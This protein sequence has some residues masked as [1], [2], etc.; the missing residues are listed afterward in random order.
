MLSKKRKF[1]E[2][3]KKL[4]NNIYKK[5]FENFSDNSLDLKKISLRNC[6]SEKNGI[7]AGP[8]GSSIKKSDYVP[9]GFRVYGQEQVIAGRFDIG[10]YYISKSKYESLKSCS[11]KEDDI[12]IS[13]VGTFGK[14]LKVPK[15]IEKGIIN[16][17]L[18][19]ITTDQNKMLPDFLVFQLRDNRTQNYF[20]GRSHGGTMGI[21]NASIL[22]EL[23]VICPPIELQNK[24]LKKI[25]VI[26]HCRKKINQSINL[27]EKLI[28]SFENNLVQDFR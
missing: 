28:E 5:S 10:D 26:N 22:K 9:K 25:E 4:E 20:S 16:P 1:I 27:I 18:L 8:F 11:V 6:V 23:E 13:L 12:L 24:F 21:L 3:L 2:N 19:K 17:R 14:I 15:G 7:K